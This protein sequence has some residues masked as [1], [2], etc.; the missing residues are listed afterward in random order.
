M[1]HIFCFIYF[2]VLT[3]ST[4]GQLT[5]G[6]WL[7]GGSGRFYSYKNEIVS[8][9][10]TTNG[11]YTQI[12]ISPNI[13]YFIVDKFALGIK[14]TVSTIKGNYNVVSGVGLGGSNG[15]RYS[16]G[17]FSRYY[18][19]EKE[20]QTNILIDA[21]YQ[22]GIIRGVND[23]KGTFNNLSI[24][25]GPVIYFNSSVGLEFLLGYATDSEKYTS[26]V[27]CEQ[28]NGFQFNIGL[29]IHLIK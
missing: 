11:K 18:F 5:K 9:V 23:T 2:L 27:F 20:K 14:S 22:S 26:Q 13:G 4:F 24:S 10:S 12:D 28:R 21:S 29:Q 6:H 15:Q 17:V 8:S 7:V 25:A 3:A 1:K 16:I 19:L